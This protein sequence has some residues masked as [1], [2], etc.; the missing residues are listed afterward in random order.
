MRKFIDLLLISLFLC[1]SPT[2]F[3]QNRKEL[4]QKRKSLQQ[5][6]QTTT[7][8][9]KETV[10]AT[11]KS[12]S[13]LNLISKKIS[14]RE[15][16]VSNINQ[17]IAYLDKEIAANSII[18]A[19]LEADLKALKEEYAKMIYY[20]SKNRSY[21]DRLMFLFSSKDF[22][23]AYKRLKYLQQYSEYR[24]KQAKLIIQVQGDLTSKIENL[25]KKRK[26]KTNLMV[27]KE[28]EKLELIEDKKEKEGIVTELY[29]KEKEIRDELK[30]KKREAD[31]LQ[32][33][34]QAIIQREIEEAE[35]K[36]RAAI[37]KAKREKEL[38]DKKAK[39]EGK[40]VVAETETAHTDKKENIFALT[41][42]E[43]ELSN[44][45]ESNRGKL[46]WPTTTGVIES[47]YGEHQHPD[48]PNVKTFNNGVDI[49]TDRGANARAIFDGV[50]TGIV[51][52]Q[53]AN[54]AVIIRHGEFLTVYANLQSVSV[55][56]GDKVSV[57]QIIGS[58]YTDTD[59]GK[60][61]LHLEVWKGKTKM[62]PGLW[63]NR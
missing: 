18:V 43:M 46:P 32:S 9:L 61:I 26:E 53:G 49:A 37:A 33:A 56:V 23:Q 31:Q 19:S 52:I 47:G 44:N 20:A 28:K 29:F 38:A 5:D 27:N 10:G 2:L 3:G 42:A 62:N 45:F 13:Q 41:P 8:I 11:K 14:I 48:L 35:E 30:K 1:L 21:Y 40:P 15:E 58:I 17:Q 54:K 59:E 24:K 60:T 57:K 39:A 22:N 16:L 50:V 7:K 12:L 34:I 51:T 25:E 6:I 36:R 63:L 55:K 4:E